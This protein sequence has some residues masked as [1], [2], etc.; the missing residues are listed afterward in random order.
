MLACLATSPMLAAKKP[1]LEDA[2]GKIKKAKTRVQEINE[3]AKAPGLDPAKQGELKRQRE[4]ALDQIVEAGNDHP[5]R[6]TVNL[7]AA[8]AL[9]E[10]KEPGKALP[11]AQ[12]AVKLAPDNPQGRVL[13]G[14]VH[15]DLGLYPDAA[16]EAREALSRQPDNQ[17]AKALLRYAE[18]RLA[19]IKAPKLPPAPAKD[20]G[21]LGDEGGGLGTPP[22]AA[23]ASGGRPRDAGDARALVREAAQKLKL[24]D[25][26]ATLATLDRAIAK[27]PR[28]A[29][30]YAQRAEARLERKDAA[31]AVADADR[32]RGLGLAAT[33]ALDLRSRAR[34][35][36]GDFAAAKAD[37]EA[38]LGLDPRNAAGY[39]NRA[40]ASAW[41]GEPAAR[42]VADLRRAAELE[43]RFRAEYEQALKRF[44]PA[45]EGPGAAALGAAAAPL[46]MQHFLLRAVA[47]LV[48][49]AALIFGL[50]GLL[51]R[52]RETEPGQMPLP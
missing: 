38:A 27:D 34:L 22:A 4:S 32:A 26:D 45:G 51:V 41:L 28:S 52:Q 6:E 43:Q 36:G 42:V 7:A 8:Q 12:Q 11:F 23:A 14:S 50:R 17:A 29:E 46:Y 35:A 24:G 19:G 16:R 9:Q 37:A 10:V 48:G 44:G 49:F 31:G 40:L 2:L 18:Q 21:R 13:L 5:E 33:A 15:Y 20:D 39:R 25:L 47:L 30:A 1:S 3:T